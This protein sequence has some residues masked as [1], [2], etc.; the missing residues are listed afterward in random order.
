MLTWTRT[1][2]RSNC[3]PSQLPITLSPTP[4][5]AGGDCAAPP[6]S[7]ETWIDR[8]DAGTEWDENR[9]ETVSFTINYGDR[10]PR[11]RQVADYWSALIRDGV[12]SPGHPFPGE[13]TLAAEYGVTVGTVRA[14]RRVLKECNLITVVP[15]KGV[16]VATGAPIRPRY[17][18][19]ADD[20]AAR[21]ANG[22][23]PRNGPGHPFPGEVPL[24]AEYGVSLGTVRAALRV[25]KERNLITVVPNKGVFVATGA[26]IRPRYVAIADDIVARVAN[27]T[28]PRNGP[29]PNE[30]FLAE[31]YE[32]A[33]GTVRRAVR[34]LQA[35]G[36]L[37]TTQGVGTFVAH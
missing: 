18:A 4:V 3:K 25:L 29:L 14:A 37:V 13:L 28:L 2:A 26:P 17:V 31:E 16:F 8:S 9:K 19:I 12:L 24:A 11:Y 33:L 32:V 1:A 6:G 10:R 7:G 30:R 34:T 5:V 23:L 27:G 20:I 22:T 36:V 21:V 35:R 15:G